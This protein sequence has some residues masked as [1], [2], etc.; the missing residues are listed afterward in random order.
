[1]KRRRQTIRAGEPRG[2]GRGLAA[3]TLVLLL[4]FACGMG[5]AGAAFHPVVRP[6]AH[7]PR[8]VVAAGHL[9]VVHRHIV[10]APRPHC[11]KLRR[12]FVCDVH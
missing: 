1:M 9:S 5:C 4:A 7:R 11:W 8:V 10:V 6:A 3:G 12:R 2:G